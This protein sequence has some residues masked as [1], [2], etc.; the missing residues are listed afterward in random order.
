MAE[1]STQERQKIELMLSTK[2]LHD[3]VDHFEDIMR[4]IKMKDAPEYTKTLLNMEYG[5]MMKAYQ[6][7]KET[8][9]KYSVFPDTCECTLLFAEEAEEDFEEAK[10]DYEN[11]SKHASMR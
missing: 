2:L 8:E 1:L 7:M 11:Y 6:L 5:I 9:G 10:E 3:T 4:V